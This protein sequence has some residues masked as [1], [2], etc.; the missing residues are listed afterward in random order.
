MLFRSGLDFIA[1]AVSVFAGTG[2][3]AAVAKELS[4][5]NDIRNEF[6]HPCLENCE[7]ILIFCPSVNM[8]I[9]ASSEKS[10]KFINIS[11]AGVIEQVDILGKEGHP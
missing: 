10:I 8:F 7:R 6:L 5:A 9:Q 3:G 4:Q 2:T 11:P 1:G